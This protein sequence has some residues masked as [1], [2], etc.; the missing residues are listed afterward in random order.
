MNRD[1]KLK[2]FKWIKLKHSIRFV[3]LNLPF[4]IHSFKKFYFQNQYF[5]DGKT[6]SEIHQEFI[7][8]QFIQLCKK[9]MVYPCLSKK[10]I[11]DFYEEEMK[12]L[13]ITD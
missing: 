7:H 11:L 3:Y 1:E 4:E 10:E 2:M 6:P 12:R 8:Y 5:L 9:W 13:V